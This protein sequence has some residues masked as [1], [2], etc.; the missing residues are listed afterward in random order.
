MDKL[1]DVTNSYKKNSTFYILSLFFQEHI[2]EVPYITMDEIA[3][4]TFVSKSQISKYVR[5]LDYKTYID[6]KDACLEYLESLEGRRFDLQ[7]SNNAKDNI[8]NFTDT[9]VN[10]LNTLTN[11]VDYI[12]L[13][14]LTEQLAAANTVF[15]FA[16]G[17]VRYLCYQIQIELQVINKNIIICDVDF[18]HFYNISD[19]DLLLVLSVNGNTFKYNKRVVK[20]LEETHGMKWLITCQ[21]NLSFKGQ[22]LYV[23]IQHEKFN[24]I[25]F[26]YII[27]LLIFNLKQHY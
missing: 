7:R 10:G 27:D 6:F 20:R 25:L 14:L 4:R 21:N 15:V 9:M 19:N 11:S 18:Q 3:N 8:V 24:T 22:Q 5:Y 26:K 17:D 13:D 2:H 12:R 16:Q 23:P 1:N